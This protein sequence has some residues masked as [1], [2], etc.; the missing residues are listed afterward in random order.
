MIRQFCL[1]VQQLTRTT[2]GLCGPYCMDVEKCIHRVDVR[3]F[4]VHWLISVVVHVAVVSQHD[5]G[6][7]YANC[8]IAHHGFG[9]WSCEVGGVYSE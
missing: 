5:L 3:K 4:H 2:W 9:R 6:T 7:V 8:F 1:C